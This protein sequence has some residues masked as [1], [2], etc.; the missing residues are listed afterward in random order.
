[1]ADKH[2]MI[3]APVSLY[4]GK[5]RSYLRRKCIPFEE[6]LSTR[7]VYREVIVPRTGVRYIPILITCDDRALQD[8]TEI[9]DFLEQRHPNL[10]VYPPTPAQ[11]LS[12]LLLEVYGDEWLVIPA[13]H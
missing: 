10:G 8:T 12:A 9:I 6:I 11:R 4:S 2:Q 13:M 7:Q 3:G 1:M 5:L